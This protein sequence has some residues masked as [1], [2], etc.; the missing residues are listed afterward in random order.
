MCREAL[1]GVM[2]HGL[3]CEGESLVPTYC[4]V[5]REA[6]SGVTSHG[7]SCEGES[8]VPTYCNVCREALSG[9]TSHGLSCEGESLVPTYCNV[10]REALSGVTSHGL[11]C[12]GE[13]LVPTYCNVCREVLSGVM[14]SRRTVCPAKVSRSYLLTATCVAVRSHGVTSHGLSCEG[15]SLVPTYCNVCREAL[16]GVTSHGLSCEGESLV[17]T[18]CNVCR[19]VLSG[20]MESRRTVC[21]AKVSRS[22]LLTATCVAVRSHGVTSHGLSCE[23]ESLVPTYCDWCNKGCGMCYPVCGM[24]HIKEPL[25][26]IGTTSPCG[27]SV[28]PLSLS[29][30]SF[31]ICLMPYNHK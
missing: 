26:L 5:C 25:L 12:E 13:S 2:S 31:T 15:E 29:E 16:S 3:S 17:P 6:L 1:S 30:W 8:L 10:C 21:P 27:S 11:S 22:Y 18:Y 28:F 7:L 4:N 14:E 9:V 23:G 19:E 20:V 24:V